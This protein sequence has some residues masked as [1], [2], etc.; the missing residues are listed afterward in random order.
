MR[1]EFDAPGNVLTWVGEPTKDWHD[2]SRHSWSDYWLVLLLEHQCSAL[3]E[4][5]GDSSKSSWHERTGRPTAVVRIDRPEARNAI[6]RATMQ[7]LDDLVTELVRILRW[8]HRFD[9]CRRQGTLPA[10]TSRTSVC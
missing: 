7:E 6:S 4:G 2:D 5:D 8:M 1:I 3:H 9:R 10:E